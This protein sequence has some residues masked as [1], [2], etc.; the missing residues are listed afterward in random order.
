MDRGKKDSL[1]RT[2][3]SAEM[4]RFSLRAPALSAVFWIVP[5]NNKKFPIQA[6]CFR[7]FSGIGC[8]TDAGDWVGSTISWTA[9]VSGQTAVKYS[10]RG[11]RYVYIAA[12]QPACRIM[13]VVLP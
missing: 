8:D 7:V 3:R 6:P 13:G 9:G 11:V 1:Q 10:D 5:V 2:Q 4:C 12:A